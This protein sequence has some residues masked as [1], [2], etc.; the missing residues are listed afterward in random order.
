[1]QA[2][3]MLYLYT[4]V[5]LSVL[6]SLVVVI[7]HGFSTSSS[8]SSQ[9]IV[10]GVGKLRRPFHHSHIIQQ[11]QPSHHPKHHHHHQYHRHNKLHSKIID[12]EV[13]PN[14]DDSPS[15]TTTTTSSSPPPLNLVE[16]SQNQDPEWKDMK[17]AFCDEQSNTYIDCTLAFYVKDTSESGSGSEGRNDGVEEYALGVPCEVPI[18]VALE[19]DDNDSN[20]NVD[21]VGGE[22]TNNN[23]LVNLSKVVPINPDQQSV[24][25]RNDM[26]EEEKEEIFQLAARALTNEYDN[27]GNNKKSNNNV[28]RMKKTPRVLTLECSSKNGNGSNEGGGLD[29]IIGDWKEILL[30][31][32][33]NNKKKKVGGGGLSIDE[34]LEIEEKEEEEEDYFDKI[35]RRDLG[36]DYMNLV[37][38]I[39]TDEGSDMN[40]ELLKLFDTTDTSSSSSSNNINNNDDDDD[41]D[42]LNNQLDNISA[43]ES[44]F[45]DMTYDNLVQQLQPSA[46]LRL[47]NFEGPNGREYTILRPLRPILLVGKED[48]EDYTRRILL[49]EEERREVLPR[50]EGE[51]RMA[52][53]EAGFFVDGTDGD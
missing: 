13:I 15:T 24:D 52:L 36:D 33:N 8:S 11:L 14:N 26:S 18:V 16:Y 4:A 22:R 50:L 21:T 28:I 27:G 46:A 38:D 40:Q 3:N 20:D 44:K 17:I 25:E 5:A 32:G 31:G 23:N 30:G 19:T 7:V 42:E 53:E 6:S 34:A 51:C 12:V 48:P 43:Q 9:Q 39:D 1:M 37:D 10:S 2:I 47:L 45:K 41:D 35:M 29:E 49:S